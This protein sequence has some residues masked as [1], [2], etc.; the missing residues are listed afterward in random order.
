MNVFGTI[1]DRGE[2][3]FVLAD[4]TGTIKVQWAG[5][6][7]AVGTSKV[8]VHGFVRGRV[9]QVGDIFRFE[10]VRLV[11]TSLDIWPI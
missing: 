2:N 6:L 8:L 1:I 11:A 5:T 7:P 3:E 4:G 9:I 10:D